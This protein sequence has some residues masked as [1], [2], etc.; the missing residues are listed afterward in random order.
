MTDESALPSSA[1]ETPSPRTTGGNFRWEPPTAAELQALMPGYA[2]EKLLGRGGMG[3]VYRGVQTNLDRP[4]AI[5]ILPPGVEKED[6]SFAERFKSEAKLMARLNHPAVVSVYDFGKTSSG[7]LYFAM[8]YVDGSDVQQMIS[9]Q[10]KLPPEH[11]LAITA[12]VCDA[13]A[14]AHELGI[15]HRDI[16]PANVL[17]NM[18]GQ[19]KVADFGLAKIEDPGSHGL[20]K[21]GYAMGTPDYVA[22]EA[23]MLGSKV[24]GRADLYAVGV[25]LY[26][27]LT[28]QIPRGAWHPA[29]VIS[30][31][32][33][34]RFDHI[35]LK[36]MQYDREQRYQ[37][38]AELRRELD[39]ILSVPLVQKNA[40]VSA[41]IPMA[42]VAQAP[43]PRSAVQKPAGKGPQQKPAM[44]QPASP[45]PAKDTAGKSKAP[46]FIG[47]GA[48]AAIGVGAFLMMGG[49]KAAK[50]EG[51]AQVVTATAASDAQRPAAA[52]AVSVAPAKPLAAGEAGFMKEFEVRGGFLKTSLVLPDNRRMLAFS[53]PQIALVDIETGRPKWT[54]SDG[55][56]YFAAALTRDGTRFAVYYLR[57]PGGKP[58]GSQM[59]ATEAK[60]SLRETATGALIQDWTIPTSGQDTGYQFIA[61][62][63][64]GKT[65]VARVRKPDS[66]QSTFV[67]FEEGRNAPTHTWEGQGDMIGYTT[68][69]LNDQEFI[70]TGRGGSF[71]MKLGTPGKAETFVAELAE[72]Y[73]ALSPDGR[74][75]VAADSGKLGVWD[76]QQRRRVINLE[77]SPT[78]N[79]TLC[80]A[81]T[82]LICMGDAGGATDHKMRGLKVWE[83][84]SGRLLA[85]LPLT[86]PD[87]YLGECTGSPN[88]DFAVI[89]IR[90]DQVPSG[91]ENNLVQIWRLP[92]PAQVAAAAVAPGAAPTSAPAPSPPPVVPAASPSP[93]TGSATA[94]TGAAPTPVSGSAASKSA[95]PKFPVGQWVKVFTKREDLPANLLKPDSGVTW[96][97]GVLISTKSAHI[98]AITQIGRPK[99]CGI[100]FSL[101]TGGM[102]TARLRDL[103]NRAYYSINPTSISRWNQSNEKN[104]NQS[105]TA[106]ALTGAERPSRKYEFC[107]IGNRLV[108]RTDEDKLQASIEDDQIRDGGLMIIN[109][110]KGRLFDIE[111]INLDGLPEAE[112]LKI[113]GVDA[114]G[115]DTRAA[116][117]AQ[118]KNEAERQKVMQ[119]AVEIPELAVL[120][121]QFVKLKAER[122]TAPFE[123][124]VAKLNAGYSGGI[125]R[126]ISE[127]KTAGHLDGVLALEAEKKLIADKRPI[128]A[129]DGTEISATLKGL[130]AIYRE[131]YAKIAAARSTN[132]QT[133]ITPLALRL[134]QLES[135]LTQ[136]DRVADAKTVR[137]YREKLAD[138]S[139]NDSPAL[140]AAGAGGSATAK[141]EADKS[142]R[143]APSAKPGKIAKPK[144]AFTEREAAEWVLSFA[145]QGGGTSVTIQEPGKAEQ[146]IQ[147]QALLPKEKFFV[148]KLQCSPP[149]E[150]DWSRI[151]DQEIMRLLGLEDVRRISLP[152]GRLTQAALRAL[153]QIPTL[154]EL[155]F[156]GDIL[157]AG[158]LAVLE[159]APIQHLDLLG[160]FITDKAALSVFSSMKNLRY[161]SFG[162]KINAEMVAAMPL[163]PKL[164]VFTAATNDR[165]RDDV[166][167]L[168]SQKF[169]SL[170]RIDFWGGKNIEA[171]SLESLKNL[172]GLMD[173][174]VV[175]TQVDDMKLA[176]LEGLKSLTRLGLGETKVTDTCIST[177][178]TF[179]NLEHL[180]IF[181][182]Q[183]T[184][185]GLQE[186]AGIRSLKTLETRHS[187]GAPIGP[188]GTGFTS[189]GVD[190][191]EKKRPDV[192]VIR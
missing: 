80:F 100:R 141:P 81:G 180:T 70:S 49:K 138:A 179:K 152:H 145:A 157:A 136:K 165:V 35:I 48:V 38:S 110:F 126:K 3:A 183:I 30:P 73:S 72:W 24:D 85:H 83:R 69:A 112:A 93:T 105:L 15:V 28:G 21:T 142:E 13:L 96:D 135:N 123:A 10:K 164:E 148:R 155:S 175:G 117:V 1:S 65:L 189:A 44:Q 97:N 98:G 124:G 94:M 106:F 36:A 23:L 56:G 118:E 119:S 167:P 53:S 185:A 27:M 168:L 147:S 121:E 191:F 50:P 103:D 137:E 82:D 95:D 46:L 132:L 109:N 104:P 33:D 26:Q 11:A 5:K 51:T 2:I 29:S 174:G 187:D 20:T 172:K 134:K 151:T 43:A 173:V 150:E 16:K 90:H 31:G 76:T 163:L 181:N 40:P 192:K 130:R 74:W 7:L 107:A 122:V 116:L 4:V 52:P 156:P 139:A 143:M 161:L 159:N 39:T 111:V 178:K 41:A 8:E 77:G 75:L 108:V 64:S 125:D 188:P 12:H 54:M 84:S 144:N 149:K 177:L 47:I 131:A 129:E 9:A 37:S 68:H 62:A 87:E 42:E 186:I 171:K 92:K 190:A 182:T 91:G 67:C 22:P 176:Q 115:N 88:G 79:A 160:L 32:T 89:R 99:N 153:C 61:L 133:L 127:E 60:I 101:D 86:R 6:P 170:Q 18:K 128:P 17:I 154:E 162:A 25:M 55:G 166:L 19:V 66:K 59:G 169:P 120:H 45:A 158:D 140:V 146:V 57:G 63:P 14:A 113:V 78:S 102:L 71:L 114:K 34:V 58:L 184:D